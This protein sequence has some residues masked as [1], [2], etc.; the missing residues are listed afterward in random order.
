MK[1]GERAEFATYQNCIG[2]GKLLVQ[3][4]CEME[5]ISSHS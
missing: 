4:Q 1:I 3:M 2:C 5:K